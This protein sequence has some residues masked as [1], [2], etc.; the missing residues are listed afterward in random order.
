MCLKF[1]ESK[2]WHNNADRIVYVAGNCG[3]KALPEISG[4]PEMFFLLILVLG[5]GEKEK[6]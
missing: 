4:V 6:N 2:I 5:K 3:N 1:C